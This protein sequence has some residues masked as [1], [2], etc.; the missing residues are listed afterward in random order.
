MSTTTRPTSG[1]MHFTHAISGTLKLTLATTTGLALDG[2]EVLTL[3]LMKTGEPYLCAWETL[4]TALGYRLDLVA[5]SPAPQLRNLEY[6]S[7]GY[8]LLAQSLPR[9]IP[10]APVSP[11]YVRHQ[12][13]AMAKERRH[14]YVNPE[15]MS[16]Q[17]KADNIANLILARPRHFIAD[18]VRNALDL[19]PLLLSAHQGFKSSDLRLVNGYSKEYMVR[20]AQGGADPAI[21][22]HVALYA[23]LGFELRVSGPAGVVLIC[24]AINSLVSC[25]EATE[26]FHRLRIKRN[27][28][29]VAP[30]PKPR[31]KRVSGDSALTVEEICERLRAGDPPRKIAMAAKV[32]NQRIYFIAKQFG[33]GVRS[34]KA[35]IAS[36]AIMLLPKPLVP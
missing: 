7:A 12:W 24:P 33:L 27:K 5:R 30:A 36:E 1:I 32:S 8:D 2:A 22:R 19:V 15:E 3:K 13:V 26:A 6:D 25:L 35:K 29:Y 9:E 28:N 23:H 18:K 21:D 17:Q 14:N 31:K 34:R 10:L 4:L 16:L 11:T 20:Y